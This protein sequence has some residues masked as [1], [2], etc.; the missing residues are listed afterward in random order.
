MYDWGE[1]LIN[2]EKFY[3]TFFPEDFDRKL[4]ASTKDEIEWGLKE[5]YKSFLKF[6]EISGQGWW[7]TAEDMIVLVQR[8]FN[9][10]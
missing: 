7:I 1:T 10:Y 5:T 9:A 8:H 6:A 2:L 3:S 4:F